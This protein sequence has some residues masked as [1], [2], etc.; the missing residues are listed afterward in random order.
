MDW[1]LLGRYYDQCLSEFAQNTQT[2]PGYYETKDGRKK[3]LR[4]FT[5]DDF[6]F[7]DQ[8]GQKIKNPWLHK[9]RIY[10]LRVKWRIQKKRRNRE[11]IDII[12]DGKI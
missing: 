5:I 12:I 10:K 11:F 1:T 3:I 7:Y 4:A 2:T 8:Q 6:T 9:A